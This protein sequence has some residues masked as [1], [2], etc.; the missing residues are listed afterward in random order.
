[1]AQ[2][3]KL[4][5][6]LISHRASLMSIGVRGLTVLAGFAIAF[7]IG[8]QLGP[9]ALGTYALVT[10]TAMFLSIL[11]V[12]GLDLAVVKHYSVARARGIK[13][14]SNSAGRLLASVLAV[15][16][17]IAALLWWLGPLYF[18]QFDGGN[19]AAFSLTF[20]ALIFLSRAFTRLT[21]SFLRSQH[22]YVFSQIVEGLLIPLPVLGLLAMG[23][24]QSV[25]AVLLA[26]AIA[27]VA[28]IVIGILSSLRDTSTDN[29]ALVVS[30]KATFATSLPL[31]VV[32]IVKNFGDWYGL[33][34]VGSQLSVADAGLYRLA[35][36]IA[37]A[38]PIITIGVFG[39]YSP[40]I[41]SA[42][43]EEDLVEV[44]RLGHAATKLSV[45][46]VIPLIIFL[47][48]LAKP[49]LSAVGTEFVGAHATLLILLAG[50]AIYV[51]T[52]PSG[53]ILALSG[54]QRINLIFACMAMAV[55]LLA[56][57][58]AVPQ[59]GIIGAAIVLSI[60]TAVQNVAYMMVV[61][62]ILGID[63]ISGR[64]EGRHAR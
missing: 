51:A 44:A 46:L 64:Y 37:S 10:Q 32:A 54:N 59:F 33:S 52:G 6:Y 4:I 58:M 29:T 45:V 22:H 23:W 39:V 61:K 9:S 31:L 57:P 7:L 42:L 48:I 16:G 8:N 3:K 2:S 19:T 35:T 47:A 56:F 12:G 40:K 25:E 63:L 53:L 43:S 15:C 62:R 30:L 34:I 50:Q 21:S 38:I 17:L 49:L 27:G 36:Q 60:V 11:A 14:S 1:M 41:G 18:A 24:L 13:P 28:A 26:T 20:L 55:M 5:D